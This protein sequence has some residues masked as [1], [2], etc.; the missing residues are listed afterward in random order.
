[1]SSAADAGLGK[2]A[3]PWSRGL[4]V[5][6]GE[7]LV[8]MK[9]LPYLR[10]SEVGVVLCVGHDVTAG[11][12]ELG[13]RRL[14]VDQLMADSTVVSPIRTA[15]G[16]SAAARLWLCHPAAALLGC[17]PPTLPFE[18]EGRGALSSA[19]RATELRRDGVTL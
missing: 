1:M 6:L 13:R 7:E 8:A 11:L 5:A 15:S 3:R 4:V 17:P 10:S 16:G 18:Q 14:L 19:V 2:W 12:A 9:L